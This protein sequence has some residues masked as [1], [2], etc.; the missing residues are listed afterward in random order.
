MTIDYELKS[1]SN[2]IMLAFL[3]AFGAFYNGYCTAIF[4]PLAKP[5]LEK[6]YHYDKV[7]DKVEI[8]QINGLINAVFAIGAMIGVLGTGFLANITGRKFILYLS[9]LV[10]ISNCGL[11][12]LEELELLIVARFVSGLVSGMSSIGFIIISELLPNWV[13]GVGNTFGYILGTGAMLVGYMTQ[14]IFSEDE[15][16]KYYRELLCLTVITSAFRLLLL[17]C[18]LKTD[19]PKYLFQNCSNDDEAFAKIRIA[20]SNVY[21][22]EYLNQAT[23]ESIRTFSSQRQSGTIK[24]C[25]MFTKK[26]R[27]RLWSGCFLAIAQQMCGIN[28]FI[29]YST[30]IFDELNGKG[31]SMTLVIGLANFLGGFI[32]LNLIGRFGRKY[33][34][35]YGCG[36]QAIS[37]VVL[38]IGIQLKI[39][40]ILAVTAVIYIVAFAVGLGGSYSAYLCE[41]LPPAGVGI[42]MT[43]QWVL[44]ALIGYFTPTVNDIFGEL[45]VLIFFTVMCIL[46]FLGLG[47]WTIETKGKKEQQITEQFEHGDLK[48]MSFT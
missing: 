39:F 44:T 11:Y 8:D 12:V 7:K 38:V 25:A 43:I 4:N 1:K 48:F 3:L 47:Q 31:K 46:L 24:L 10:A 26:Y 5:V 20:Y 2:A 23:Y 34:F 22:R 40:P 9:E 35:V 29:F 33:N 14:N 37:M 17:P 21:M 27:L 42:S 13:S 19:T 32:A 15:L 30:Q 36:V 6:V 41:I 18:Y 45:V 28:F 16:V